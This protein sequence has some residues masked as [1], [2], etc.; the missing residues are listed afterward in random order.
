MA[1]GLAAATETL[2]R[3]CWVC[4]TKPD[5]GAARANNRVE[6]NFMMGWLDWNYEPIKCNGEKRKANNMVSVTFCICYPTPNHSLAFT[7]TYFQRQKP[8]AHRKT[9]QLWL[10]PA[11]GKQMQTIDGV[12]PNNPSRFIQKPWIARNTLGTKTMS[13]P[14]FNSV[15]NSRISCDEL[16][17]WCVIMS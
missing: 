12:S 2:G 15:E 8:V 7:I 10:A 16:D 13:A 11:G 5:D 3:L 9:D 4:T 1:L 17:C 6:V 14:I